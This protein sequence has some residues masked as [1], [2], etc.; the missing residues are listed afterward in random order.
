M[1]KMI[2]GV[3]VL[4]FSLNVLAADQNDVKAASTANSATIDEN[5][6]DDKT[7]AKK[8]ERYHQS[9]DCFAPYQNVNGTMKPGAF[10]HCVVVQTPLECSL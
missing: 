1:Y 6:S 10:E 8:W 9:Q 2:W 3:F 7:C 5:A 4:L